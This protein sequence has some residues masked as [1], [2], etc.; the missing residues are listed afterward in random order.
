MDPVNFKKDRLAP[1]IPIVDGLREAIEA[2][3]P[4]SA[5]R[6]APA[7]VAPTSS[8]EVEIIPGKRRRA[9]QVDEPIAKRHQ[10]AKRP[11]RIFDFLAID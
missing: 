6:I 2:N 3:E 8:S 5:V 1:R 7:G 10:P 9:E 11:R 4:A